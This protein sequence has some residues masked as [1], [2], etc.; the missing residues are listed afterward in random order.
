MKLQRMAQEYEAK[1]HLIQFHFQSLSH[2][3]QYLLRMHQKLI[4]IEKLLDL[5]SKH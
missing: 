2:P 1:K 5:K 4:L 3:G